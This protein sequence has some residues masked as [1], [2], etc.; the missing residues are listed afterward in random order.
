MRQ[1]RF[2]VL[3]QTK[4]WFDRFSN[5]FRDFSFFLKEMIEL[6]FKTKKLYLIM[7]SKFHVLHHHSV[8][9]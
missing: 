7:L 1:V 6:T 4:V 3:L 8:F 2:G 5:T 9:W